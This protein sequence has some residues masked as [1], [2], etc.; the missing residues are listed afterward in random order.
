MSKHTVN[1][2]AL[3][4][5]QVELLDTWYAL[6]SN[7]ITRL[8]SIINKTSLICHMDERYNLNKDDARSLLTLSDVLAGLINSNK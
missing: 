7:N 8:L 6:D 4:P 3:S 2:H 5:A 1:L